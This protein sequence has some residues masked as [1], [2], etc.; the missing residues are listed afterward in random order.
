GTGIADLAA[1][2]VPID[3]LLKNPA[4]LT[5]I[6]PEAQPMVLARWWQTASEGGAKNVVK[7]W[8]TLG[9]AGQR[10]IGGPQH[11]A[12]TTMV[13]SLRSTT[14][15]PLMQMTKS[16]LAKAS[17]PA[18]ALT[19]AGHP[20]LA[21]ALPL[22][23]EITREQAPRAPLPPPARPVFAGLPAVGRAVA[24]PASGILRTAGQ[25]AAGTTADMTRF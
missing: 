14:G 6:S 8:D 21:A 7:A 9:E 12:L 19:Y 10:A 1:E 4:L 13:E 23:S 17:I 2:N 22:A 15:V 11:E 3:R 18:T 24:P 25:A 16:E 20:Y 5:N